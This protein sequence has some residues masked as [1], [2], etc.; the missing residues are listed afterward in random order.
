[1][2][3][4]EELGKYVLAAGKKLVP[5]RFPRPDGDTARLWGEMLATVPLPAEIWPE[6][7][8]VFCLELVGD[9][10]ATPREL[11]EAAYIVRDRWESHPAKREALKVHR[12]A[13]ADER[14][15]QLK[16]GTFAKVRGY[17]PRNTPENGREGV[18]KRLTPPR[19]GNWADRQSQPRKT[20][21]NDTN[22]R[23]HQ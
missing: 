9:R 20:A 6:A 3:S 2:K 18:A 11:R 23:N 16:D 19:W 1:M 5:D 14:D 17:L 13:L 10:M 7:V 4:S 21:H 8:K 15:R 22:E 12:E